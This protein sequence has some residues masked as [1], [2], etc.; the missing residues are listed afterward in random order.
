LARVPDTFAVVR[1]GRAQG[2]DVGGDLAD[3]LL[4]DATHRDLGRFR[5]DDGDAG[6]GLDHHGVGETEAEL[7]RRAL[8]LATEADAVDLEILHVAFR[9]TGD[10]VGQQRTGQAVLSTL[11][12]RVAAAR[13]GQHA[14]FDGNLELRM[15]VN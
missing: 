9:H 1:I 5:S 2:P 11:I 14:V 13:D 4:V 3:R 10:G 6:R 7:E 15:D 8:H 12:A